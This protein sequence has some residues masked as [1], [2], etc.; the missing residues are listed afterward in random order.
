MENTVIIEVEVV[1][2]CVGLMAKF[3]NGKSVEMET[4]LRHVVDAMNRIT[5]RYNNTA[6]KAVLFAVK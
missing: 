1:N 5:D 2:S 6:K 4:D 3:W